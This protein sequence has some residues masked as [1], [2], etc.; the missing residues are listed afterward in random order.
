MAVT[1]E[2][3]VTGRATSSLPGCAS[4]GGCQLLV[5]SDLDPACQAG[6]G[7][8]QILAVTCQLTLSSCTGRLTQTQSHLAR[9]SESAPSGS[10]R[11]LPVHRLAVGP[12]G[13]PGPSPLGARRSRSGQDRASGS[14][15]SSRTPELGVPALNRDLL[16]D[17]RDPQTLNSVFRSN[18]KVQVTRWKVP[19]IMFRI[20]CNI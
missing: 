4:H 15:T 9:A 2:V 3:T 20:F 7:R 10:C 19:K 13:R 6:P 18:F 8:A 16:T 11:V 14:V 1:L 12:A 17:H 5:T